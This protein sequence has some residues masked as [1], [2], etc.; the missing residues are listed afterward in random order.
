V[1]LT[2]IQGKEASTFLQKWDDVKLLT[3]FRLSLT[4]VFSSVMAYLIAAPEISVSHL[5]LLGFGG[6]LVTGAAS[7][8]NQVLERDFD[9]LMQRTANRPLPMGRMTV[10]TAVLIAG[11]MSLVGIC[12]LA[13]LG[14]LAAFL[15]T[16]SLILYAFVYTPMKRVS[17]FAVTVGA[18]P[19]ALPMMIGAVAAM[20]DQLTWLA[21]T[22]FTI[23]FLWQ[24][25]HFWAIAW[26]SHNDY[27]KAGFR[28]LPGNGERTSYVG[29]LSVVYAALL[30]P[31]CVLP[32]VLGHMSLMIMLPVQLVNIGFIWA[33]FVFYRQSDESSA[34]RLLY[35]S[36]LYLP[37]VLTIMLLNRFF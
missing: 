21:V 16:A 13:M 18:I 12:L 25:P 34:R 30:I 31:V 26:L 23:Q 15:G 28:L 37:L 14:P 2:D 20:N 9:K 36:F 3:K 5:V 19:G 4:V 22:L 33:A 24:F 27:A 10:G 17:S 29:L 1:K 8:L 11:L 7:A 35:A 6:S 32:Y